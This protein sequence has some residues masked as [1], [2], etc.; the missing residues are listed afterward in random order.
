MHVTT[1]GNAKESII[2]QAIRLLESA[3]QNAQKE[4]S[5]KE[6][7]WKKSNE[8]W[9]EFVKEG[10]KLSRIQRFL[11]ITN[12]KELHIKLNLMRL[13]AI[14][15]NGFSIDILSQDGSVTSGD[16]ND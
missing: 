3:V 8:L 6:A 7:F 1:I 14:I 2:E 16:T 10:G 12:S 4:R 9:A 15:L 13:N 5:D 11:S